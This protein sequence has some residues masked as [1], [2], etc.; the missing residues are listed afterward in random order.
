MD[1]S[2]DVGTFRLG[3][4]GLR[5][6]LSEKDRTNGISVWDLNLSFYVC[7]AGYVSAF[8]FCLVFQTE[9][10]YL[11]RYFCKNLGIRFKN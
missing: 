7:F 3:L 11:Y 6:V 2:L 10:E 4:S 8:L 1:E 9:R 5:H